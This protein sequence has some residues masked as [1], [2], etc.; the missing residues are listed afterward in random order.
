MDLTKL[1]PGKWEAVEKR[2]KAEWQGGWDVAPLN[3]VDGEYEC[4]LLKKDDAE[5]IALAHNAFA[6]DAESLAWWEAN[7]V[8]HIEKGG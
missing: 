8:K 2:D 4:G 1:T 7:R 3:V 5:F 6:G